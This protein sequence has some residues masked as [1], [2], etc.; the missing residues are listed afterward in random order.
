MIFSRVKRIKLN[1]PFYALVIL[2]MYLAF[3]ALSG[4]KGLLSWAE[5]EAEITV[6]QVELDSLRAEIAALE[7]QAAFFE[8]SYL[9]L[10]VLDEASREVLFVT[11][12]KDVVIFLDQAP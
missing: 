8:D 12:T 5:Y 9:N 3:H 7:T 10:D 6:K 1:L 11:H 2:Y 4:S